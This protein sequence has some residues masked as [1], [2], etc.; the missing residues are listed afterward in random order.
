MEFH[1][2]REAAL[3]TTLQRV[4]HNHVVTHRLSYRLILAACI[5]VLGYVLYILSDTWEE[6]P[7]LIERTIA[8]LKHR[9]RTRTLGVRPPLPPFQGEASDTALSPQYQELGTALATLLTDA[10]LEHNLSVAATWRAYVSLCADVLAVSI[11][12][13]VHT[14]E[15]VDAYIDTL[16]DQL[17]VLMQ[18]WH[19][20]RE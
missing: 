16:R 12:D 15:E 1:A 10:G 6:A 9:T 17:P 2:E 18:M 13:A 5:P 11:H 7:G 4:L 3:Y 14:P 20:E 8:E 19:E